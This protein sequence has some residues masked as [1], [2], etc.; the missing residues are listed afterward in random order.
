MKKII[1]I[2]TAALITV[3]LCAC[4]GNSGSSEGSTAS[5]ASTASTVESTGSLKDALE[6]VKS[7]VTMPTDTTDYTA[8]K[9]K[10]T[11]GIEEDRM[12]EFAGMYC[13]DGLTQ[14]MVL[15]IKAKT[16]DDVSFIE[17]KLKENRES[18]Y[19]VVKNYTP[20]QQEMIEKS[21][22]D[23]NG[24]YVCLVISPKA[25]EIKSIFNG[26]TK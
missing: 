26:V 25:D 11:F 15:Y 7:S 3:S 2:L 18:I 8:K 1:A 19:K 14:D 23:V 13:N 17:S 5:T 16:D 10:R 12:E 4:G 22:V 24:R 21:T 6:N 9:I 20:D